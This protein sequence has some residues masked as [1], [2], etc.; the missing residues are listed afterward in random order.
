MRILLL[1]IETSPNKVYVWSLWNV[2]VALNQIVEPGYTLSWAAKWF[3]E[4]KVMYSDIREGKASMLRKVYDL[5]EK[6]DVVVHYNG[7][8]FDIPT[9]NAEFVQQGWNPPAPFIN[10]DL[11]NVVKK[12]F[13]FPSNK[14]SYVSDVLG[15]GEKVPHRG[16]ELW[17]GCMEGVA[18]DWKIMKQYNKQDVVLL[19]RLYQILRPWVQ[20]HPNHGVFTNAVEPTCPNCGSLHVQKRGFHY[21]KTMTYQRYSCNDCGAW[22]RARIT[23]VPKEDR[24]GVLVGVA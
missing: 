20:N 17:K 23:E 15:I 22:S 19:E 1:D 2:N 10:I 24:V 18:S 5:I 11:Y 14:L 7:N 4:D 13:R 6:A 12:R 3:D 16:M 9:L 8:S 21:T